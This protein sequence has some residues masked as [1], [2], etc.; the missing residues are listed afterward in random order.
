LAVGTGLIALFISLSAL[1]PVSLYR[2]FQE[3]RTTPIQID[4]NTT[5]S[6]STDVRLSLWW[7]GVKTATDSNLFFGLGTSSTERAMAETANNYQISNVLN[8]NDPHN[9]YLNTY[10]SLGLIGLLLLLSCYLLRFLSL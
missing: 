8:S 4:K 3:L 6:N 9:Q 10:I 5:Y 7:L 2:E 1:N